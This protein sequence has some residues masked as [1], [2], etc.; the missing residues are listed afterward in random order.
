MIL[1]ELYWKDDCRNCDDARAVL[2]KVGKTIPFALRET[3]L[4][5]GDDL[6]DEYKD[7]V[8][9]IHINKVPAFRYRL[10]ESLFRIKLQ[11]VA[12]E[13]LRPLTEEDSGDSGIVT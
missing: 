13:R 3:K 2:E 11:Q 9:V 6:Y 1:V 10:N 5:P 7:Q 8:P 12:N 4:L